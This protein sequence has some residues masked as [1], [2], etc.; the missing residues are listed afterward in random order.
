MVKE[1]VANFAGETMLR[2]LAPKVV[3][4]MYSLEDS[5]S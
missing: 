5:Y 3:K 1:Y 4:L 2:I